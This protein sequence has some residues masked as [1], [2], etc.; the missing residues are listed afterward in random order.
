ML[1]RLSASLPSQ[2][3]GLNRCPVVQ[4]TPADFDMRNDSL[5]LPVPQGPAADW[6][7]RQQSFFVNE[8]LLAR[9][10]LV[11]FGADATFPHVR[12]GRR[13]DARK[14]FPF[15]IHAM[16]T[17]REAATG[18]AYQTHGISK[19]VGTLPKCKSVLSI[20]PIASAKRANRFLLDRQWIG[21][22]TV[23][24]TSFGRDKPYSLAR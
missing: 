19:A 12:T 6:Q 22:R 20:C 9:R 13:R 5:G 23:Q 11:L 8:T 10:C 24:P 1:L 18:R 14:I 17:L 4:A 3:R 7:L 21:I 15:T 2:K 16:M